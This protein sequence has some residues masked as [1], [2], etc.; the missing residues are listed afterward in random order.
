MLSDLRRRAAPFLEAVV[1]NARTPEERT[2]TTRQ[3]Y[4]QLIEQLVNEELVE[5]TARKMQI[6]VTSLE[7]DQAIDNVRVQNNLTDEQFW[8]AVGE[9]GFNRK[10]YREDVRK[11]LLRL[12]VTN[13]KVRARVNIS[14]QVVRETYDDRLRQAR[15]TQRFRASH[16]FLALP[17]DASATDVAARMREAQAIGEKLTPETF[18]A[19][20]DQH[21]GG[22]LGWLDQG[23]LPAVLEEALLDLNEQQVSAPVRGS[24]GIHLFLVRERQEGKS[25]LAVYDEARAQI[26]RELLDKAMQ[27]QEE[28]FLK[29]LRRD[30]VI[31]LRL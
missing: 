27:R 29:G 19:A 4:R 5:Q 23:D 8:Q 22:D 6:T 30:A 7:I 28:L 16:V 26:H 20:A 10:Q 15:R 12:K 11:Q 2:E 17:E 18:D 31:V 3:L 9:Q 14:E 25:G 24:S 13:Q 21:G 1:A